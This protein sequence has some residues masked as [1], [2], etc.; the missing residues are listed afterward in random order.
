MSDW[1]K[2]EGTVFLKEREPLRPDVLKKAI[3]DAGF[4]PTWMEITAAGMV[5]KRDNSL[6][7]K[8]EE[9]SQEFIL[10]GDRTKEIEKLI[11]KKVVVTGNVQ[12]ENAHLIIFVKKFE[13]F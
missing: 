9:I 5:K 13:P 12:E 1:R 11:E 6:I 7:L 4:T 10:V 8:I 2:A 3:E